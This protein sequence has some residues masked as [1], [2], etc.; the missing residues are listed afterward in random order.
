MNQLQVIVQDFKKCLSVAPLPIISL[1]IYFGL[2]GTAIRALTSKFNGIYHPAH[3]GW[4]DFVLGY[5]IIFSFAIGLLKLELKDLFFGL[6]LFFIITAS[7]I[8]TYEYD[9]TF[10]LDGMVYF[11]RFFLVFM[12]AKS[13]V[14]R[15]DHRTAESVLIFAYGILA[16]TAIAWYTLQFGSN[17]RMAAS[18]MSSAS[19]GQI[20]AVLCL[21]FY[22]RKYYLGLFFSFIFLFLTFSRTALLL[23]FII[24]IIQNRKII[25]WNLIKYIAAFV[26]LAAVGMMIMAKHGGDATEVVLASR[27]DLNG[28]ATMNG[29]N[30]IWGHALELLKSR[31]IPVFGVGFHMAPSLIVDTN[32]VFFNKSEGIF[33]SPPS[34]HSIL[35]EYGVSLGILS[36][37]IF[38]Y[39][40][41]RIWQ[42]FQSNCCPAFFIFAFFLMSQAVDYTFYTPKVIIFWA[43]LFGMAEGQWRYSSSYK[44]KQEF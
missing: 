7:W 34:F 6:I 36:S 35:V 40:I 39:L 25:P 30:K 12:F 3:L 11:F 38:F 27:F 4:Y 43:L 37:V 44:Q 23:F 21:I 26:I 24:I 13:L 8:G 28:I 42:T 15:L 14:R 17:N 32:L 1:I 10:I 9:K 33:H 2:R 20:S 16:A 19:F 41:K 31:Q 5:S 18:A 22:A 29:R